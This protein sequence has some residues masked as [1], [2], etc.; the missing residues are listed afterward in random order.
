MHFGDSASTKQTSLQYNIWKQSI[1]QREQ[2]EMLFT[3]IFNGLLI[4]ICLLINLEFNISFE[5][6]VEQLGAYFARDQYHLLENA[7]DET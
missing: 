3:V 2:D 4:L 5:W 6:V 7:D 1:Q